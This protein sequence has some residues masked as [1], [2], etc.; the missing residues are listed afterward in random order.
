[1]KSKKQT[2]REQKHHIMTF[3]QSSKK[4]KSKLDQEKQISGRSSLK[5]LEL[6]QLDNFFFYLQ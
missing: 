6:L 3:M 5:K 1:M 4:K 2:G